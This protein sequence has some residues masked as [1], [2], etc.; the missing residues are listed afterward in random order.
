MSI[1]PVCA[2]CAYLDNASRA[3]IVSCVKGE[4]GAEFEARQ[5]IDEGLRKKY[6]KQSEHVVVMTAEHTNLPSNEK[7]LP[8]HFPVSLC[9]VEHEPNV[10]VL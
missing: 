9:S 6:A 10:C 2:A 7:Q 5:S 1:S 8:S 4:K 3:T